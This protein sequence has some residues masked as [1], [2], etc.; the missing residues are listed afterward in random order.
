MRIIKVI[1]AMQIVV[2]TDEALKEELLK[3]GT[4]TSFECIYVNSLDEMLLHTGADGYIDL[5]FEFNNERINK[6]KSLLPKPV[7]VNSVIHILY[8]LT[9]NFIRINGWPTFLASDLVEGAAS[10]S[11]KS[12]GEEILMLFH[13]KISWLPDVP[14]F[15]SAR[16]ISKIINEAWISVEEGVSTPGEID[17]AMRLGTNYPFGPLEWAEKIG[18][19]KVRS[20]LERL[21]QDK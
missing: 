18:V 2:L 1:R 17:I 6:L 7:L 19:G 21:E 16:V 12:K 20:L 4:E 3:N 13:K 11:Q 15:I 10:E 14:G 5:L 8:D 9:A